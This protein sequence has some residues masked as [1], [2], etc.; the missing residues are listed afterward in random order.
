MVSHGWGNILMN[1]PCCVWR[2]PEFKEG[3]SHNLAKVKTEEQQQ[4]EPSGVVVAEAEGEAEE[5][6]WKMMMGQREA[7]VRRYKEKRRNRLF[8][9]RIRYQV[10]KIN[11]EKR[12][13]LK[14]NIIICIIII[15]SSCDL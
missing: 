6:Q 5:E 15:V 13:R 11:A 9:K 8:S 2:V 4:Q 12:P 10:R 3:G 1:E 7:S 14:V